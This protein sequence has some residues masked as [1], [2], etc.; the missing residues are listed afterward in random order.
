MAN[1]KTIVN[2]MSG[3]AL[4][5]DGTPPWVSVL[6][7]YNG[8]LFDFMSRRFAKDARTLGDFHECR[9]WRD[10]SELQV[11][12]FQDAVKDYSDEATK[13]MAVSLKQSTQGVH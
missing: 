11:K 6:S 2:R 12:W 7:E 1:H 9:S 10:V 3:N 5:L 13:L 8:E 4:M